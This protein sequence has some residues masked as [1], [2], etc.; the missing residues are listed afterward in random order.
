MSFLVWIVLGLIAGFIGSKIVNN[1]GEGLFL[2][3]ILG[4]VGAVVGGW[5]AGFLGWGRVS[6]L[7]LYSFAVAIGGAVIGAAGIPRRSTGVSPALYRPVF[8]RGSASG[9]PGSKPADPGSGTGDSSTA[10]RICLVSSWYS[11]GQ[12]VRLPPRRCPRYDPRHR[13]DRH[14]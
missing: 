4:I 5:L 12:M 9:Q 8:R 6:G 3:I 11:D 7:S 1:R 10:T 14:S 13:A 2:D